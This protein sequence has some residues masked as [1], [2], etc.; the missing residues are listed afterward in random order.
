METTKRSRGSITTFFA[1]TVIVVSIIAGFFAYQNQ[2]L[3]AQLKELTSPTVAPTQAPTSEP[4]ETPEMVAS[5]SA[6][7]KVQTKVEKC[8]ASTACEGDK[9]CMANPTAVFCACMGGKSTIK[10]AADGSQSGVC[11]ISGKAYDEWEYF[12]S[13]TQVKTILPKE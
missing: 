12:R 9:P 11:T 5:P 4:T 2:K 6:S 1:I 13:F 8:L 3:V 10:T 7:P